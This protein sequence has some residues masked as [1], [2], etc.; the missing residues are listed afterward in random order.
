[1]TDT[2]GR[3]RTISTRAIRVGSEPE[4][5]DDG[6]KAKASTEVEVETSAA[7]EQ[8]ASASFS[9]KEVECDIHLG[10]KTEEATDA[11]VEL[12]AEANQCCSESDD[13][14][15]VAEDENAEH[16]DVRLDADDDLRTDLG[17]RSNACF[18]LNAEGDEGGRGE[19]EIDDC[20]HA[21]GDEDNN[22]V[23]VG[24]DVGSGL[25]LGY[26]KVEGRC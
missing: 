18:V 2:V 10:Q 21:C 13:C 26:T 24:R 23:A 9:T 11:E 16:A 12:R 6:S 5:T 19:L 4:E 15:D 7:L 25:E 1:M 20:L 14:V 8:D 22:L 17:D 3:G